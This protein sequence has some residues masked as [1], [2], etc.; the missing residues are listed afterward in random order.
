M[1]YEVITFLQQM[2]DLTD[3]EAIRQ[4]AFNIM[5]HYAL[6]VTDPSDFS[7]NNFV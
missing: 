6:N 2:E 7:R 4:F 1:L 5:W 3:E